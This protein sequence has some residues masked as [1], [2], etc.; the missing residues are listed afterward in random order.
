MPPHT[1]KPD[2]DDAARVEEAAIGAPREVGFV[3]P[4]AAARHTVAP[5]GRSGWICVG[6][7]AIRRPIPIPTPLKYIPRHVI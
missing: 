6:G 4:T 5:C 1:T 7:L 3:V 2:D